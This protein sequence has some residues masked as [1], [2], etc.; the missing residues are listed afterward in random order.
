MKR[1]TLNVFTEWLFFSPAF[2]NVRNRHKPES[3]KMQDV[4]LNV[5]VDHTYAMRVSARTHP[6][7]RGQARKSTQQQKGR[8]R[9]NTKMTRNKWYYKQAEPA[10]AKA[11]AHTHSHIYTNTRA[12]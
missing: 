10:R 3:D 8:R 5:S 6:R 2:V 7:A 1:P 12:H 11:Q 4:L 9:K